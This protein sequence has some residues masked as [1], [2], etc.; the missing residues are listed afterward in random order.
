MSSFPSLFLAGVRAAV[1][2]MLL[3]DSYLTCLRLI[4]A[5]TCHFLVCETYCIKP[6]LSLF[7]EFAFLIVFIAICLIHLL[8]E[9]VKNK[10]NK[11]TLLSENQHKYI[12]H[13][14]CQRT[15]G[16]IV[17]LTTVSKQPLL[18]K[19]FLQP[20]LSLSLTLSPQP[21]CLYAS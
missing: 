18:L 1:K 11:K 17:S 7:E 19:G 2:C 6:W 14:R 21:L 13:L 10:R 8:G 12:G 16:L 5:I 20:H 3:S 9:K 4:K 15:L